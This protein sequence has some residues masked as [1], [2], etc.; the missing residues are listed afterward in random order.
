G[1]LADALIPDLL[2]RTTYAH[3]P[4][5]VQ[6]VRRMILGADPEGVARAL[7]AMRARPDST[8]EL[9]SITVPVLAIAGAEDVP[10]PPDEARVIAERVRNGRRRIIPAAG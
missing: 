4:E 5:L 6:R 3:N 2:G 9:S 1:W 8:P 10:T 7:L